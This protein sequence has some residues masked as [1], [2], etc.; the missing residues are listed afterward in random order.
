MSNMVGKLR[1][2][3]EAA[4]VV[5]MMC[6]RTVGRIHQGRV[7]AESSAQSV[8][9]QGRKLRCG[10]CGGNV[11]QD[12]D[13]ASRPGRVDEAVPEPGLRRARSA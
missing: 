8:R 10:Y 12:V 7:Y 5:C 13:P 6:G 1:L 11:Y 2:R 4:A 9:Q 3:M